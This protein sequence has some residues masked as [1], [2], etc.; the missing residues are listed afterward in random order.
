AL[1]DIQAAGIR[2]RCR[3]PG[4]VFEPEPGHAR[5]DPR[6]VGQLATKPRRSGEAAIRPTPDV[7]GGVDWL[8]VLG[9]APAT[10]GVEILEAEPDRIHPFVAADAAEI[11][12]VALEALAR[13]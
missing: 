5:F 6:A 2:R 4:R 8:A 3:P 13:A 12:R 7:T 9:L 1:Q 10:G 11:Q